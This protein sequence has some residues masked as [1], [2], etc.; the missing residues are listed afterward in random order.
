MLSSL[1]VA[2][3]DDSIRRGWFSPLQQ[4]CSTVFS[5][6]HTEVSQATWRG[7]KGPN[8]GPRTRHMTCTINCL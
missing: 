2:Y 3:F 8:S 1:R 7:F 4:Q 5:L 6:F